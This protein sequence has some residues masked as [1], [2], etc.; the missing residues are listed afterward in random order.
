MEEY[1]FSCVNKSFFGVEC[2]GC[3]AQRALFF[4]IKGE[5]AKA[6]HMY[7]AIYTLLALLIFVIASRFFHFR[8]DY[9]IKKSLILLNAA[10]VTGSYL[11]KMT[12]FFKLI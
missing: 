9:Q 2:Y 6:F 1:M 8:N 5:F 10:I 3:G 12:H 11:L 4:L 7:P